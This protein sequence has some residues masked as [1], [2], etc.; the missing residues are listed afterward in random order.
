M[1]S[2]LPRKVETAKEAILKAQDVIREIEESAPKKVQEGVTAYLNNL[3]DEVR[4]SRINP[5]TGKPFQNEAERA[6]AVELA[7]DLKR[8][9]DAK[10]AKPK[11]ASLTREEQ[12]RLVEE[13]VEK[14]LKATEQ[15]RQNRQRVEKIVKTASEALQKETNPLMQYFLKED[16]QTLNSKLFTSFVNEVKAQADQFFTEAGGPD[17]TAKLAGFVKRAKDA[18]FS[19]WKPSLKAEPKQEALKIPVVGT[20]SG[21]PLPQTNAPKKKW[22]SYQQSVDEKLAD[23]RRSKAGRV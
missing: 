6:R 4:T 1:D 3:L 9:N 23:Y 15:E 11:E 19:E 5:A 22:D 21:M 10:N 13:Q 2:W 16:G 8:T 20:K 12:Q 7:L 17:D 14:K 18:V